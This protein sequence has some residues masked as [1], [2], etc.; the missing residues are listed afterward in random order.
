[1]A[2][3]GTIA[4]GG[5]ALDVQLTEAR[6]GR[7]VI[8][9]LLAAQLGA[10]RD[11][12]EALLYEMASTK[13]PQAVIGAFKTWLLA[14]LQTPEARAKTFKPAKASYERRKETEKAQAEEAEKAKAQTAPTEQPPVDTPAPDTAQPQ[15]PPVDLDAPAEKGSVPEEP[16]ETAMPVGLVDA[17]FFVSRWREMASN[18][19][20]R[21]SETPGTASPQTVLLRMRD[22]GDYEYDGDPNVTFWVAYDDYRLEH[23]AL[24]YTLSPVQVI[25]RL[26][27]QSP[28][29]LYIMSGNDWA[30]YDAFKTQHPEFDYSR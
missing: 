9:G 29:R 20:G 22:S 8:L 3:G 17:M 2:T 25:N 24:V 6:I 28:T 27:N 15:A 14:A 19:M 30:R 12:V 23:P 18:I 1:M 26:D 21:P 5:V 13:P 11:Q 7:D 16:F 10:D 4:T